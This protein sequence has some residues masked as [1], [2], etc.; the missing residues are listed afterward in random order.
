[1]IVELKTTTNFTEGGAS[2][3]HS[4][5]VKQTVDENFSDFHLFCL[6]IVRDMINNKS[7]INGEPFNYDFNFAPDEDL[8]DDDDNEGEEWK[9]PV[10]TNEK[11]AYLIE[12][13]GVLDYMSD[14]IFNEKNSFNKE[15]ENLLK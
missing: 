1:M 8:D 4:F 13:L 3:N 14:V 11:P 15:L 9:E 12:T 5:E 10:I 7:F 2:M 6:S